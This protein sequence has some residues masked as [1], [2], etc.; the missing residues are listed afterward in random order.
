MTFS[1]SNSCQT[2]SNSFYLH[3]IDCNNVNIT[4]FLN[5][6][7]ACDN[8]FVCDIFKSF[9]NSICCS[10]TNVEKCHCDLL[11]CNCSGCFPLTRTHTVRY[12]GVLIDEN[13]RWKYHINFTSSRLRKLIYKFHQLRPILSPPLLK[14]VYCGI[15]QSV[16][17]Y[18]TAA[19]GGH[20][21]NIYARCLQY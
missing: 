9:S 11:S 6:F 20:V 3:H 8:P 14:V 10:C 2:I 18:A 12:L 7:S 5:A 15:V 13:L 1:I 19:W 4:N 17:E 21:K 16:A